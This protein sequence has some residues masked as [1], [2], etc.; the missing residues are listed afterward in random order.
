MLV[1]NEETLE[2]IFSSIKML[3]AVHCEDEAT[4]KANLEKYKAEYGDDIPVTAHHLIR[5]EEACYL[6]S[7]KAIALAKKTGARLHVFHVSTAKKWNCLPIKF[8]LEEK[9]I[10]AEVCIHHF[11]LPMTIMLPK[12]ISS[13]GILP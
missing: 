2:K 5:S 9:Q 1:D 6:S 8:Q 11:G 10:T 4:I 13:N 3:I 7:S 12:E